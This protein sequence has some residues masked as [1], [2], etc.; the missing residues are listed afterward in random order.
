M[1]KSTMHA[2]L[3]LPVLVG[4]ARPIVSTRI[5]P[6]L[7][8]DASKPFCLMRLGSFVFE[9]IDP[10]SVKEST[11]R[12]I[13]AFTYQFDHRFTAHAYFILMD[14]VRV[15]KGETDFS[16]KIPVMDNVQLKDAA[17]YVAKEISKYVNGKK[18]LSP[19]KQV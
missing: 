8:N 12:E 9:N 17:R 18:Q 19:G 14:S 1:M 10:V 16:E 13:A 11:G 3:I 2:L 15:S 7:P 5:A 6:D 4:C